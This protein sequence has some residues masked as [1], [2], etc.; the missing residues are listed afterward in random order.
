MSKCIKCGKELR[1]DDIGLYKK[2][3]NRGA[4][5]YMCINCICEYFSMTPER[6]QELIKKFK[7]DG[8]LLFV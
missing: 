5:E 1:N 3:V 6:A 7:E 4:T 2:L 8:C